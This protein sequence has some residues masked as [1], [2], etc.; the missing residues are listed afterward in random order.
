MYYTKKPN[1]Y[2]LY[3]LVVY[4]YTLVKSLLSELLVG[5]STEMP[6]KNI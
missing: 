5:L 3:K 2:A 4:M 1:D 6:K